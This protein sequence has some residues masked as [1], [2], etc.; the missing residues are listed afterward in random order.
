M[1]EDKKVKAF[2]D[3]SKNLKDAGKAWEKL[4]KSQEKKDKLFGPALKK[5]FASGFK[6]IPMILAF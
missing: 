1:A 5:N 4:G 2:S 6:S 3:A